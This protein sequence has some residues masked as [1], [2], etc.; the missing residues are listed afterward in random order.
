[1]RGDADDQVDRGEA[2]QGDRQH[3]ESICN[4]RSLS[5]VRARIAT[6]QRPSDGLPCRERSFDRERMARIRVV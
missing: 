2:M 4:G 3:G 5:S 1:M 6:G